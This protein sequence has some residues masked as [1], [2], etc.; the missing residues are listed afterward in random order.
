MRISEFTIQLRHLK[1]QYTET[2][3][4]KDRKR[5]KW[6]I[7]FTEKRLSEI[8]K[9]QKRELSNFWKKSEGFERGDFSFLSDTL[10]I[11]TMTKAFNAIEQFSRYYFNKWQLF[12]S[13]PPKKY[14]YMFWDPPFINSITKELE[15]DGH[16]GASMALTMRKMQSIQQKGWNGIV[17]NHLESR[18]KR[19]GIV[20]T[21]IALNALDT[22][23]AHV[24]S[25]KKLQARAREEGGLGLMVLVVQRP[26]QFMEIE[27]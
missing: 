20:T 25:L 5:L 7:D 13:N 9:S 18:N 27:I 4:E 10:M 19:L 24:R 12:D 21:Y 23:R 3:N 11:T 14:G 8:S 22:N 16:T 26:F 6:M 1:K 17:K 15:N 2:T